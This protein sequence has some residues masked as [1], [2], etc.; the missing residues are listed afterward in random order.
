MLQ[1]KMIVAYDV[2]R[3]IGKD[4]KL[5]WY[6]P[7]DMKHFKE[8]TTDNIVVMGRKTFESLP[9][10]ALPNRLN[11]VLTTNKRFTTNDRNVLVFNDIESMMSTLSSSNEAGDNRT[12]YVIGGGIIYEQLL[13]YVDVVIASVIDIDSGADTFFPFLSDRIWKISSTTSVDSTI[14]FDIVNYVRF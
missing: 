13:S 12:A 5:P 14:P 4:N 8:L 3:G 1:L 7:E 2:N 6:I 10:G 9:N 11:I